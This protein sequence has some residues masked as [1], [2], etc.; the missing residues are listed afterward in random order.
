MAVTKGGL[1]KLRAFG[2]KQIVRRFVGKRR[3]TVLICSDQ[4]YKSAIRERRDPLCVG[5]PL[6][7]V[8]GDETKK[9][10]SKQGDDFPSRRRNE[11]RRQSTK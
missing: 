10:I 11:T 7:D 6:E 9:S 1:I 4:E 3:G 2:G 5:F 8:M